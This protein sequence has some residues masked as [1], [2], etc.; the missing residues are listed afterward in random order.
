MSIKDIGAYKLNSIK[1]LLVLLALFVIVYIIPL[2]VSPLVIPDETRYS[3]IPREMIASGNWAAP[4]LNGLRYFEKPAMG[5]WLNALSIM[6]FGESRFAARFPSAL[7]TGLSALLLFFMARRFSAQDKSG[8]ITASIFLL[9]IEIFAVGSFSILDAPFSLFI[10][11]S[12]IFY[13][14]AVMEQIITRRRLF[15]VLSG[16]SCGF[17]FLTKGFLAFALPVIIIFPFMIWERKFKELIRSLWIPALVA[18]LVSLPWSILINQREPDFWNFFFWNEHIRRFT[19]GAAQHQAPIWYFLRL[20]PLA[21]LPWTFLAPAGWIGLKKNTLNNSF[22][23][24][25]LCWFIF[26]FLFFSIS[27]GKLLTYILPCFPP[28]A[29]LLSSGIKGYLASGKKRAFDTGTLLLIVFVGLFT[30]AVPVVQALGIHGVKPYANLIK[31]VILTSALFLWALIAFLSTRTA[32][33]GKKILLFISAPVLFLFAVHFAV[34]EMTIERKMPGEFLLSQS[35]KIKPGS[36]IV[37]D[38]NM[39]SSVCWYFKR[40]DVYLI[41][42]YGEFLYGLEQ[43]DSKGRHLDLIQFRDFVIKNR[44]SGLVTLI[45]DQKTYQKWKIELPQPVSETSSGKNGVV[46]AQF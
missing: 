41:G 4:H 7:A 6:A 14:F 34:P 23:K 17:A 25:C 38:E 18:I 9:S 22:I 19:S 1:A 16:I 44:N 46:F 28:L 31:P 12:I 32:D 45:A 42:S 35:E 24:F 30:I 2:G 36:I 8:L 40:S 21:A 43:A 27:S 5:Y 15:L 3:E 29:A 11:G 10:T 20:I 13:Y 39:I 33:P 37:A 26:P